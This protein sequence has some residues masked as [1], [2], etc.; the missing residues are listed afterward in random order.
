MTLK[1]TYDSLTG[2]G[3]FG[4]STTGVA[5]LSIDLSRILA[6]VKFSTSLLLSLSS[7]LRW[8]LA[9]E[10][11]ERGQVPLLLLIQVFPVVFFLL[12]LEVVVGVSRPCPGIWVSVVGLLLRGDLLHR[13]AS[14]PGYYLGR[15][16]ICT[17]RGIACLRKHLRQG[18][19]KEGA[20]CLIP[21]DEFSLG[22]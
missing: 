10:D 17:K 11:R 6:T 9:D 18:L 14:S 12:V 8:L 21:G 7:G 1:R 19:S 20:L 22:G 16:Q 13:W 5:D 2:L 3:K 4:V 15:L